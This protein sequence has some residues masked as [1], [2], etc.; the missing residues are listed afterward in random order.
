MRLNASTV[1]RIASPGKVT[2]HQARST[3]S[4]ASASMVPHS[5]VGGWAAL[6][7]AIVIGPRLG[8]YDKDG[9]PHPIR[10]H[11]MALATLGVDV[12]ETVA[13]IE[14]AGVPIASYTA[15]GD[16]HTLLWRDEVYEIEVEGVRLV[17]WIAELVGGD[18]L[19]EHRLDDA[20]TSQAE[21]GVGGLDHEAALP[22]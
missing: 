1:S 15:P 7:G 22:R 3:N 13:E 16:E 21:E 12:E 6:A 19:A 20:R 14:A 4:R 9:K 5:G 10:G 18:V 11:N 8:K 17:E 2:T